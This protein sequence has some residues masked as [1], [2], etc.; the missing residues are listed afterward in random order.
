MKTICSFLLILACLAAA[1]SAAAQTMAEDM[2]SCMEKWKYRFS[3]QGRKAWKPEFTIRYYAGFVTEGPFVTAGIRL[4]GVRTLGVALWKGDTYVDSVPGHYD[5]VF[6]G[7]YTR[8][9]FHL[10]RRDIIA[11][12]S[13]L[14]FGGGAVYKVTGGWSYEDPET[15]YVHETRMP[16]EKGEMFLTFAWQPGVRLRFGSNVHI[17]LGPT[18]ST[19]TVGLHLGLGF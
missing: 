19:Y 9:Y 2:Q 1:Q 5:S 8:R 4:D 6:T 11:F 12:Y 17:F 15:G 18:L 3:E 14:T 16:V 7:L 10:G 13:D